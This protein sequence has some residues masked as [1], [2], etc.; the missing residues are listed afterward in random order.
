MIYIWFVPIYLIH[1]PFYF[2]LQN[3][4]DRNPSR[5]SLFSRFKCNILQPTVFSSMNFCY[6]WIFVTKYIYHY[7]I[8]IYFR[9]YPCNTKP[10]LGCL[11]QRYRTSWISKYCKNL[12]VVQTRYEDENI[13]FLPFLTL[14]RVQCNTYYAD[15]NNFW[16]QIVLHAVFSQFW[17]FM[18]SKIL[19]NILNDK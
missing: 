1:Q 7:K 6:I 9:K 11:S 19:V 4:Y 3:E 8:C 2:V 12:P 15:L 10:I 5:V 16:W 18:R 17:S 13:I 14:S